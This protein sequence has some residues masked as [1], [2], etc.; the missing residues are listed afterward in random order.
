[1]TR[2]QEPTAQLSLTVD[3]FNRYPGETINYYLR[4]TLPDRF[5]AVPGESGLVLQLIMPLALK[6]ESYRLPAGIPANLLSTIEADQ[7][8][9]LTLPLDQP[10]EG[11]VDYD[12]TVKARI[13]SF[14]I[15]HYLITD[16]KIIDTTALQETRV[17]ASASIQVAVYGKGNYLQYLPALY[18]SDDFTSRFLML[19]ES[20]WKPISQQIDQVAC[21]F[22]P[23]LTP[24]GFI[25]WLTSWMGMQVDDHLPVERVR[26]LLKKSM[27][28]FQCRGTY[29]AVKTYLEIYTTGEVDILEYQAKNFQLGQDSSL[30]MGIALGTE[31]QP[32][33][34]SFSLNIPQTELTRTRYSE[35]VYQQKMKEIIRTMVPAHTVYHVNCVFQ[36]Q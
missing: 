32:N 22:D 18:E 29:Q 11:G 31:N 20:F 30:G 6:V 16:S 12:I 35:D 17:V 33:T 23:D 7:N 26:R 9:T 28:F 24:P 27:M 8:L 36:A 5:E 1:M 2:N 19:F 10:F 3:H 34:I 25:P 15:D 13:D 21:Y 4:F 14:Y